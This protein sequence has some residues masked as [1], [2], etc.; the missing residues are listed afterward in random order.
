MKHIIFDNQLKASHSFALEEYIM[1]QPKFDDEYFMFWRTTPTIMIGRFQNTIQEINT[2]FV[3]ANKIDVIRRNSGGGAIYTDENCW[4]FS[5]ITWKEKG[6]VKDFRAFTKPVISALESLGVNAEFSGRNDLMLCGKK[7]SGNAQFCMGDRFLHHGAILFDTNID[8]M[9][10]AL[11]IGDDKIISKG[12]QS[13]RERVV[14]IKCAIKDK[15]MSSEGF[16]DSI[17][18]IIGNEMDTISIAAEDLIGIKK[19]ERKFNSWN[20]NYGKSPD[21]NI[22]KTTQTRGGKFIINLYVRNGIITNCKLN[23]DFFYTANIED[24]QQMFIG[25]RYEKQAIKKKLLS[26]NIGSFHL[27]SNVDIINYF[28]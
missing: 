14:N 27:V 13:V 5:F 19:V 26:N 28:I 8:N 15:N 9:V 16:R 24:F 2:K 21:F 22:I 25:C 12:I 23:G 6:K 18:G 7:F 1:V 10:N 20:W 3:E 4:Q 17:I 11:V